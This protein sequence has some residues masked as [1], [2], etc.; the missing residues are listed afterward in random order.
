L[1]ADWIQT[2]TSGLYV[3]PAGIFLDAS[4]PVK[5]SLVSHAHGDHF[6]SGC[7]EIIA[8][9]GSIAILKKRLEGSK[10]PEFRSLP[11]QETFSSG[12]VLFTLYPAGHIPGSAMILMEYQGIRVLYTGD[13][14]PLPHPM[15]EPLTYPQQKIDILITESTFAGKSFTQQ[16]PEEEWKLFR[17]RIPLGKP[18]LLGVYALG[19]AQRLIHLIKT[20]EPKD[21]VFV[22]PFILQYQ[23]IY[24]N[25]GFY[26]GTVLPYRKKRPASD[27]QTHIL[28]PPSF[29][30][31]MALS[32]K[33]HAA[34]VSGWDKRNKQEG[35]ED[36][37]KI[38]DHPDRQQLC[39]F[40]EQVNPGIL[41]PIH[42]DFSPLE[43]WAREKGIR[44]VTN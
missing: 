25:L 34:F 8:T 7:G 29:F 26:P 31:R 10:L 44:L 21:L 14:N 18:A 39:N 41:W 20:Y 30:R 32:G 4:A 5:R 6:H 22:H 3:I 36:W 19:K 24:E 9:P 27:A 33:F 43:A 28:M 15:A 1:E 23:K 37:V 2:T 42:G 40:I 11:Y 16:T 13:F 12:G 38:S 17:D 35:I